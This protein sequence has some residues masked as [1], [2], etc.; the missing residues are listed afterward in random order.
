[1]SKIP[2][3]HSN[4]EDLDEDILKAIKLSREEEQKKIIEDEKKAYDD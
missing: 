3:K 4:S 1:M 2:F